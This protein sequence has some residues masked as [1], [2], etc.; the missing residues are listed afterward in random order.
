MRITKNFKKLIALFSIMVMVFSLAA[1]GGN[2]GGTVISDEEDE[3]E[4]NEDVDPVTDPDEPV[5]VVHYPGAELARKNVYEVRNIDVEGLT[6]SCSVWS[7]GETENGFYGVITRYDDY[8]NWAYSYV[9]IDENGNAGKPVSF[10]LPVI[11]EYEAENASETVSEVVLANRDRT[12][13]VYDSASDL[14]KEYSI[15]HDRVEYV[16]YSGFNYVG[17]GIY[18][19]VLEIESYDSMD[20]RTCSFFDVR[21]NRS[22]ESLG[23][24]LLPIDIGSYGNKDDLVFSE[25]NKLVFIYEYYNDYDN[26]IAG[27]VL[28]ENR[29]DDP[30]NSVVVTNT[31]IADWAASYGSLFAREDG[32]HVLK[33]TDVF[34][35]DAVTEGVIDV[36]TLEVTYT[37]KFDQIGSGSSY[38]VGYTDEGYIFVHHS[39]L[40]YC[41]PGEKGSIFLDYINS[42]MPVSTVNR[43]LPIDGLD[44]ILCLYYDLEDA[45]HF[46][47]CTPKDPEEIPEQ[48]VITLAFHYFSYDLFRHMIDFNTSDNGCRIVV[49]EYGFYE[50]NDDY[51]AWADKLYEDMMND[52]M[53]DIICLDYMDDIDIRPAAQAGLLA[54]I[55]ALIEEDP[56]MSLDDYAVNVFEAASTYG[57]LFRLVPYFNVHTVMGAEAYVSGYESWSVEDF[58]N[59]SDELT[60]NGNHMFDPYVTRDVFIEELMNMTGSSWVNLDNGTC[61]F[62]DPSFMRLLGY[63]MSLPETIYF[64][65][66]W[67]YEYW[68]REAEMRENGEVLLETTTFSNP[69][70]AM[71]NGYSNFGGKPSF[72]GF[73]SPNG[74]GSS[75]YFSTNYLL[76]AGSDNLDKCW[77]F[78]KFE[79]LPEGQDDPYMLP[80]LLDSLENNIEVCCED[81]VYT[82]QYGMEGERPTYYFADEEHEMP[83]MNDAEK[84]ELL[85]FVLSSNVLYFINTDIVDIIK[86]E[87]AKGA[88]MGRTPEEVASAIQ[89]RVQAYLG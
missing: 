25:D 8:G 26:Y 39:G 83:Y 34:G 61:D 13:V 74:M 66:G 71:V 14:L 54:D 79:L 6:Y 53:C 41:K 73:P 42:D 65:D 77:D 84:A 18:E 11:T 12:G 63:A 81:G 62:T 43:V 82:D 48:P 9:E 40:E 2:D 37:N 80:V 33:W 70:D 52:R 15:K 56:D 4:D 10:S 46:A 36:D 55:G 29:F 45:P 59:V 35:S 67:A 68:D 87:A 50:R 28:D 72:I 16:S 17:D 76:K 89:I 23:T 60:A 86:D 19:S 69:T 78:I 30:K 31:N 47:I 1:C 57:K 32:L 3:D 7:Y 24:S 49:K 21:W 5:E 88:D 27:V 51:H 38:S 44:K 58:L 22:G 64:D 75:I 85:D 20:M